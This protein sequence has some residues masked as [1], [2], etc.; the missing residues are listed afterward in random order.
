MEF[1]SRLMNGKDGQREK[2]CNANYGR[3]S[4]SGQDS[5]IRFMGI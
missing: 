4:A 3:L 2:D 5:P 1:P